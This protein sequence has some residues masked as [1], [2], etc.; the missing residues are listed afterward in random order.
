MF[1]TDLKDLWTYRTPLTVVELLVMFLWGFFSLYVLIMGF[2]RAYLNKQ[3]TIYT[4]I[5]AA[6]WVILGGVVDV[7]A[8]W[9]LAT[10]FFLQFPKEWLVTQRLTRYKLTCPTTWR[11]K[12][13][14]WMCTNLLDYFDPHGVHCD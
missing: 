13:A 1:L 12:I 11:G 6:P 8:N 10:L 3:L 9:T 14:I 7:F 2:Y 4:K 5:L